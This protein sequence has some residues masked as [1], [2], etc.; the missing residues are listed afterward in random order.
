MVNGRFQQELR[1]HFPVIVIKRWKWLDLGRARFVIGDTLFLLQKTKIGQLVKINKILI[2]AMAGLCLSLFIFI[3]SCDKNSTGADNMHARGHLYVLNQTDG[4]IYI[5][6][7]STLTRTDSFSAAIPSPH[8]LEYAP[9]GQYYYVVSR[10]SPGH[11]AKF[12]ALS[13]ALID[14]ITMSGNVFPTSLAITPNSTFGYLCDF[15]PSSTPGHIHKYNL[16]TMTFVD[17][18]FGNGAAS[19]D[20]MF[21]SNGSMLV[22]C[23]RNT[24]DV[25]LVY[26]PGDSV[27]I[28]PLDTNN[29]R[30]TTP[31]YGPYGVHIA[32]NDS[33]AYITCLFGGQVRIVDL[34]ARKVVDSIPM[35][36]TPVCGYAPS[37]PTLSVLTHDDKKIFVTTQCGN[38]LIVAST[39]TKSILTTIDFSIDRPFGVKINHAGTKVFV[40]CANVQDQ[41]GEI[42]VIDAVNLVKLDS[43]GVGLNSFGLFWH[44]H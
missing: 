13:N 6:D 14:T 37:G 15:T 42:Y 41:P 21:N 18:T 23:S 36:V 10:F 25:T 3:S 39:Q 4:T 17:S 20:L 11:I 1:P 7:D 28:I 5:Y 30:P 19:H 43:L 34:K 38:S 8:W 16:N 44:E 29:V 9:N 22:A 26:F 24:D 32:H 12:N 2:K 40:A 27:V 33:L 35:P 31:V